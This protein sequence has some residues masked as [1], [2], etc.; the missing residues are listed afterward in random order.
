M[1]L[2]L[3]ALAAALVLSGCA[4]IFNGQSQTVVIASKPEGATVSVTN[5]AGESV[6]SGVTPVT[7]SLKRGYGYFKA[8]T[9]TIKFDKPGFDTKEV[10]ISGGVSGW[11]IGNI[12]FGGLIGMLA[13]D[14]VTGAMYVFPDRVE[15]ELTASAAK[16]ASDTQSLQ[17]VSFDSLS[18]EQRAQGRLVGALK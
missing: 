12:L 18:A 10:V 9:Y 7:L 11:Y 2:R 17:V 3:A 13:V 6:H 1:K 14:P 4:T 5:R 16:T 8:E 15:H